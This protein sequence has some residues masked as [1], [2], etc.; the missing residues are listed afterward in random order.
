MHLASSREQCGEYQFIVIAGV[1][2]KVREGWGSVDICP[3]GCWILV[4][5]IMLASPLLFHQLD[6]LL[7]PHACS[8]IGILH[9]CVV[10][11]YVVFAFSFATLLSFFVFDFNFVTLITL[12]FCF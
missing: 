1:W 11:C 7:V 10:Y 3:G 6:G 4:V 2:G 12:C 8:V 5:G 9:S